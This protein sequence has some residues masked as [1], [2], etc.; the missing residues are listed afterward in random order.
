MGADGARTILLQ[1]LAREDLA[2]IWQWTSDRYGEDQADRYTAD[3]YDA[4]ALMADNPLLAPL[5]AEFRPPVR[6]WRS[7]SHLIVFTADEER[8]IAIRVLHVRREWR[9]L[10]GETP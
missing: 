5:H 8:L 3:L 4:M 1:P 6:L 7:G 9:A 2:D 10:L